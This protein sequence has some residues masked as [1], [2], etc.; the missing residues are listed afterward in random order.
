[1]WMKPGV[2]NLARNRWSV[3][4]PSVRCLLEDS[5]C[6]PARWIAA[7]VARDK[8]FVPRCLIHHSVRF[9][10]IKRRAGERRPW[11]FCAAAALLDE[12]PQEWTRNIKSEGHCAARLSG[13]V[14]MRLSWR[15]ESALL[16]NESG[17]QITFLWNV[18][19]EFGAGS[20]YVER[21]HRQWRPTR[22]RG[23]SN[24]ELHGVRC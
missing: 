22:T 24:Y 3:G 19:E 15:N 1:M 11:A 17:D 7:P 8:F 14:P 18:V 5:R 4:S 20:R 10:G 21:K 16:V 6:P 23:A 9:V 13:D 2:S 12:Y